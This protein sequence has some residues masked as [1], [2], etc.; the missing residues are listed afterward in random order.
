VFK[1]LT[2]FLERLICENFLFLLF[3]I[4]LYSFSRDLLSVKLC[5]RS[6]P[7]TQAKPRKDKS[8]A[9]RVNQVQSQYFNCSVTALINSGE[10]FDGGRYLILAMRPW[11]GYFWNCKASWPGM[12]RSGSPPASW[13]MRSWFLIFAA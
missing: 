10:S 12:T 1:P 6:F 4:Y 9:P 2:F 3:L 5:R 7:N 13:I 11:V 8:H